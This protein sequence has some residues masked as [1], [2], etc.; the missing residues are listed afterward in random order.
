MPSSPAMDELLSA[1]MAVVGHVEW[2]ELLIVD[3][4]P[5]AGEILD[6][7]D[8]AAVAAGSGAVAAVQMAKLTG[9]ATFFTALAQDGPGR[10]AEQQLSAEGIALH[11][12]VRR[13]PQRRAVVHL[14]D[15]GERTITIF[16][17]RLIPSRSDPLPWEALEAIDGVYFTG[18]DNEALAAARAA[19]WLVVT[20]RAG[21][22]LRDAGVRV[23]VLIH[24]GN[25]ERE[26][27]A[28]DLLDPPPRIVVTTLGGDGGRWSGD[29]GEGTWEAAPLPGERMDA[30]GAGDSFA[31]GVTTGLA[32]G[33]PIAEAVEL[34]ARCGA[35]CMTGRGP[36]AAQI[37]LR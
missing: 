14:D 3:R 37:D 31:G 23:D 5:R 25:D 6:A 24:S 16:G 35:A 18:G 29:D 33:M 15:Q 30:Y 27:L 9:G 4:L 21:D 11:A 1:R 8:F 26:R 36:Y 12:G 32:A 28:P 13:P 20:P 19:R 7:R 10:L 17:E 22:A 2:A 34:G